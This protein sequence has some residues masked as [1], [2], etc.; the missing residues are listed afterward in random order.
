MEYSE[1]RKIETREDFIVFL[2]SLK[3]D[4]LLNLQSWENRDIPAFLEAM[5]A[6]IADMDGFYQNHGLPIPEKL[7]WKIFADILIGAKLH[8]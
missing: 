7:E 5:A 1:V 4:Y 6:W 3:E 8:E 2:E